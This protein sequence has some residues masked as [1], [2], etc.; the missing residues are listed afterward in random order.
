MLLLDK[1]QSAHPATV[2]NLYPAQRGEWLAT[3][4]SIASYWLVNRLLNTLCFSGLAFLFTGTSPLLAELR[5][6]TD[7]QGRKITA[8][9]LGMNGESMVNLRMG[10]GKMVTVALLRLSADD[11]K[12]IT[13]H[14]AAKLS[15]VSLPE[16]P[17][18]AVTDWNEK[19]QRDESYFIN[20][21]GQRAFRRAIRKI[22]Q[23]GFASGLWDLQSWKVHIQG[24]LILKAWLYSECP[25]RDPHN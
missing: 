2:A 4:P 19:L 15:P 14:P 13:A 25:D 7:V 1:L 5:E 24:Y 11:Q 23:D 22:N 8:E 3:G 17:L 10:S 18:I 6:Y 20:K 21:N 12:Y 16:K 9:F